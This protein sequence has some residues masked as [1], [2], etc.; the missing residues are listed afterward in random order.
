MKISKHMRHE[1]KESAVYEATEHIPQQ[2][3]VPKEEF[4]EKLINM[5]GGKK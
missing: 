5:K 3:K 2:T 4:N 1:M